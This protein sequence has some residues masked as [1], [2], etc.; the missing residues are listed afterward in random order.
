ME[1]LQQ[2]E[3]DRTIDDE[4]DRNDQVQQARHDQDEHT[5]EQ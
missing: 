5:R 4:K 1:P 3:P 2:T